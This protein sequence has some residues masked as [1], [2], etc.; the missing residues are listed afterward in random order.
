MAIPKYHC[1]PFP[2]K[3]LLYIWTWREPSVL[4]SLLFYRLPVLALTLL[5]WAGSPKETEVLFLLC[6]Q[7]SRAHTILRAIT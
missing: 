1:G 5:L 6:S 4:G 3:S 7:H 2:W